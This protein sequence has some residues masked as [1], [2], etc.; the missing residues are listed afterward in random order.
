MSEGYTRMKSSTYE[1][2]VCSLSA[3]RWLNVRKLA[4]GSN[5]MPLSDHG[6]VFSYTYVR[7]LPT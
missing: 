1:K 6:M 2:N 4:V 3:M 7:T 5:L